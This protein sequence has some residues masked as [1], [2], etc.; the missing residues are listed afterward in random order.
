MRPFERILLNQNQINIVWGSKT[1]TDFHCSY[2]PIGRIVRTY[3]LSA[4][5]RIAFVEHSTL[6]AV[7]NIQAGHNSVALHTQF[8]VE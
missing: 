7:H 8:E 3:R 6:V 5:V 4:A 1:A 2:A